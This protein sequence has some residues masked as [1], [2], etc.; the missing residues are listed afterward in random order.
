MSRTLTS[1]VLALALALAACTTAE[2]RRGDGGGDKGG[3][4]TGPGV[5]GDTISLGA[6][7]DLTAVFAPNSK[8]IL[9]GSRLYWEERNSEGGVCGRDVELEV[10]DHGYDPQQAVS[11]YR[12]MSSEVLALSPVL[13][14]PVIT[15]LLPSFEQDDMTVGMAAWTSAVLPNDNI[16]ITGATY[17][18]EMIN[19]IDYLMREEGLQRGDTVG[20]IYFEGDFGENA[21]EGTQFAAEKYDLDVVEQRI[22]PTD[23]DLSTQVNELRRRGA[24]AILLSVGSPQTAS[25]AS[26]AAASG[27]DVPIIGNGPI[28]TPQLLGTPAAEALEANVLTVSSVA[29]PSLQQ[30]S[31]D[32]FLTEFEQAHPDAEP[33]QNGSMYGYASGQIM[34]A[35]LERA[36]ENGDL[37]RAG[38]REALHSLSNYDSGGSV[39]GPLDYSN[40]A[41][42][43]TRMVY[44]SRVNGDVPGGLEAVGDPFVSPVAEEYGFGG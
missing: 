6:L 19:G 25:V 37:T 39:A 3:V 42:A 43:P 15:A 40:P 41:E 24:K 36:C 11:L 2:D 33:T 32:E 21:L 29:P 34:G 7:V 38:V 44:V 31:V 35:A 28:F 20:H 16:Q 4:A 10:E 18:L 17:D 9:Q 12:Q 30:S 5:T 27:L 14:S 23:T 26:V 8:S 13:G 1:T 22:V